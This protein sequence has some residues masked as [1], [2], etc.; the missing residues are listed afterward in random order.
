LDPDG[1][2]LAVTAAFGG[3]DVIVPRGWRV[4]SKGTPI[5]GGFDN[6]ADAPPEG[7]DA[8]TLTVD[9]APQVTLHPAHGM[10]MTLERRAGVP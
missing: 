8:P 6:T 10:R 4:E 1:A 9:I 2:T 7:T 5:F 3:V